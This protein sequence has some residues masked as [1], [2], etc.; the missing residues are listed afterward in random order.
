V[1]PGRI[2]L[3]FIGAVGAVLVIAAFVATRGE[4]RPSRADYEAQVVQTRDRVS[5]S[6]SLATQ[7]TTPQQVFTRLSLTARLARQSADELD[8]L[9]SPEGLDEEAG[10]LVAALNFFADELDATVE[11][12]RDV[13]EQLVKRLEGLN[14]QGFTRVQ[15]ALRALRR[16][17]IDVPLLTR[18]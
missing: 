14:F 18:Y 6:L 9:G 11:A 15:R 5:D 3:L 10:Q 7:A 13:R 12:L 8:E 2:L 1:N 16:K 4:E 17:G